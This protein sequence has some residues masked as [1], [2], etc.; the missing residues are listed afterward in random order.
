M[1]LSIVIPV[2]NEEAVLPLLHER[3]EAV[4]T[5]LDLDTEIV[6]VDDGSSDATPQII[7]SMVEAG[8][9]YRALVLSRNFGH[10][11]AITAGL[12]YARGDAV[13]IMDAD[14]Q[15][16]PELIAQMV[17]RWRQGFHVVYAQRLQR[18]VETWAKKGTAAAFYLLMRLVSGHDIPKNTGDFRLIDR[19]VVEAFK[20]MP[21]R[22]RFVRGLIAWVGFRQCPVYFDRPARPAGVT[23]YPWRKM[24]RFA[25]DGIFSFSIVPLR[26]ALYG[27]LLV[28]T[29]AVC[30]AMHVLYLRFIVHSTVP[31]WSGLVILIL[32]FGGLNLLISGL[33]GEYIGRIYVET[34]ARPH[35]FIETVL[36]KEDDD[37]ERGRPS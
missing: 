24:I 30:M 2:F 29:A 34:K 22:H 1:L 27:G 5:T 21:E 8:E 35:Y 31:G 18:H 12:D 20:Q 10:Q 4:R 14:L 23:K 37:G 36:G 9:A 25:L 16:P 6:F 11:V 13:V 7:R 17:E 32:F 26:L 28:T 33:L 3:L 15:D 19:K